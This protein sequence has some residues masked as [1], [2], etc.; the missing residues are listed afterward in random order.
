MIKSVFFDVYG[1][2]AHFSPS[3][4]KIQSA[5]C[6][7]FGINLTNEN[8]NLGYKKAD[9]LMSE[10]NA[11]FPLRK[12]NQ[13]QQDVFFTKYQQEILLANGIQVENSIALEIFKLVR[14]APRKLELYEDVLPCFEKIKKL[15]ITIGLISNLNEPGRFL[16]QSL[17]LSEKVDVAVTSKEAGFEKPNPGIFHYALK[18]SQSSPENAIH[19]GD[20]IFSD[21]NGA[22]FSGIRP[23][24]LD[25]NNFHKNFTRCQ[26]ISSLK[27]LKI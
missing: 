15:K 5:A 24:L 2:I 12:M 8:V 23:V 19:V 3:K 25:R 20:Q 21:V 27:N 10:Q 4:F 14:N 16:V 11:T 1:T 18:Q 22:E 17:G 9:N 7:N 26:K 13:N 6:E